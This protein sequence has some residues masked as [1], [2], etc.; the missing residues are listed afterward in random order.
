MK[1]KNYIEE[2]EKFISEKSLSI[3]RE[4]S[5]DQ[6]DILADA[7]KIL[8]FEAIGLDCEIIK[9]QETLLDFEISSKDWIEFKDFKTIKNAVVFF[10]V[11][12][13]KGN[14]RQNFIVVELV[15][16]RVVLK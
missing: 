2:N 16:F 3:L 10:G 5:Q 9:T 4:L 14:Q 11:Q 7:G 8:D 13:K 12:V 15:K 6:F 1:L